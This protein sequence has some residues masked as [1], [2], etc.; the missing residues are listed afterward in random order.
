MFVFRE[1][2]DILWFIVVTICA[3]NIVF[4]IIIDNFAG[5]VIF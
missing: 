3:T 5:F 2:M 1:L 4:G